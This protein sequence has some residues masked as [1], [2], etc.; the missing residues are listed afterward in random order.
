MEMLF[1]ERG[2]LAAIGM[3]LVVILGIGLFVSGRSDRQFIGEWGQDVGVAKSSIRIRSNGTCTGVYTS[4][5]GSFVEKQGRWERAGT[6][7]SGRTQIR[8]SGAALNIFGEEDMKVSFFMEYDVEAKTMYLRS[9]KAPNRLPL[10]RLS[11]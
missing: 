1:K 9:E 3:F 11:D 5:W 2:A 10:Q 7:P 4:G 8:I 6:S